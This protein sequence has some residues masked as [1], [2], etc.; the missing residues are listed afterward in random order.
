MQIELKLR[1][2]QGWTDALGR[3]RF[4]F[5]RKGFKGVELPVDSDP[6]SIAFQ[7][8]YHAALRG[9][10]VMAVT[11]RERNGQGGD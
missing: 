8:L 4:R 6:N 9:E 5:R 7:S 2:I 10:P 3:R 1:Y 11:R